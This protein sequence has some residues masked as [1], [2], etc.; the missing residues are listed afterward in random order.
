[1]LAECAHRWR[2]L[3]LQAV[4]APL[5]EPSKHRQVPCAR[6][7]GRRGPPRGAVGG[8]PWRPAAP[9]RASAASQLRPVLGPA[10]CSR[11]GLCSPGLPRLC[12]PLRL[13]S[14]LTACPCGDGKARLP[15]L[16]LGQFGR[17]SQ[18]WSSVLDRPRRPL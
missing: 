17:F 18:H 13:G 9:V 16:N 7:S 4:R 5:A 1:M 6:G 10:L 15:R 12:S 3:L 8:G 2:Q 14:R 11:R